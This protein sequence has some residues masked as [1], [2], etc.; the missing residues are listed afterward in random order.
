MAVVQSVLGPVDTADLGFTLSHEH[1]FVAPPKIYE[2]YPE[3][4]GA[5]PLE[6]AVEAFSQAKEGGVDTVLEATT[7][8]L[9]RNVELI[10]EV[11]RRTGV[12]FI[13][14]TGWWMNFPPYFLDGVTSDQLADLF[15]RDIQEGIAG[16]G[17]KAGIL[18]SAS[19]M[20]GVR[21]QEELI[22]RAVA[23]A[24]KETGAPITLHSYS[25]GQVGRQQIA[26]MEDEGVP[27]SRVMMAH[28]NDTTNVEYLTWMLDKGCFL[29]FDRYPGKLTSPG[30]RTKTLKALID[31]GYA[32]RI[33]LSHD[34]SAIWLNLAGNDISET[35]K[36]EAD[37]Y[38]FLYIKKVVLPELRSLGV[39]A[40]VINTLCVNAPRNFLEGN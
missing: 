9:G 32:D 13:A 17:I 2:E 22:L 10:A 25:P 26:I 40:E 18:K 31:A 35:K 37:Q 12:T 15:V 5:D 23:R 27:L 4:F 24:H 39:P 28:S 7:F 38:K 11:S 8:D 33:C 19:D 34:K 36:R 20:T 1:I 16:T 14:T 21:P 6:V 3:L 30:A 29:G